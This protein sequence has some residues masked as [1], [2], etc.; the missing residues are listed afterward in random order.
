MKPKSTLISRILA[1]VVCISVITYFAACKKND[2][3]KIEQPK[4]EVSEQHRLTHDKI[5]EAKVALDEWRAEALANI[6]SGKYRMRALDDEPTGRTSLINDPNFVNLLYHTAYGNLSM[7]DQYS[8]SMNTTSFNHFVS[9]AQQQNATMEE[10]FDQNSQS[11]DP[12]VTNASFV[13]ADAA[14]VN[15]NNTAFTALSQTDQLQ[16]V[17]DGI[18]FYFQNDPSIGTPPSGIQVTSII[19]D[20]SGCLFDAVGGF[21]IGNYRIIRD[22][23]GA[24]TGSPMGYAFIYNMAGRILKQ[25]FHNA[26]GWVGMAMGFAWCMIF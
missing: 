22:I 7:Y 25:A 19:D 17:R 9:A 1:L 2:V 18:S 20:I 11:A 16:V 6:A 4:I 8:G 23:A 15:T 10:I 21:L 26:G 12:F 24:L 13:L 5:V 14:L 3:T